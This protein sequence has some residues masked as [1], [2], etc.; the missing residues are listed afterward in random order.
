MKIGDE[1]DVP[2]VGRGVITGFQ[3]RRIGL[4]HWTYLRVRL[5][6]ALTALVPILDGVVLQ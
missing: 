4:R 5:S 2:G 1:Y 3:G 6:A